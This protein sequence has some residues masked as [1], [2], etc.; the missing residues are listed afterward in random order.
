MQLTVEMS[1][2]TTSTRTTKF[3][4]EQ[5]L[6]NLLGGYMSGASVYPCKAGAVTNFVV[7]TYPNTYITEEHVI[8]A[9][10][11][12]KGTICNIA[13]NRFKKK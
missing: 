1:T 10:G 3:N 2:D 9:W 4:F 5:T 7:R 6:L 12:G 13:V 11:N 8:G